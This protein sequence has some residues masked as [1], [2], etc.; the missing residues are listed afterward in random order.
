M[1]AR[2]FQ[3]VFSIAVVAVIAAIYT[4][5]HINL[6]NFKAEIAQATEQATG[7]VLQVDGDLE[8]SW[9]L[10][11]TF[12]A[13]KVSFANTEWGS[14]AEMIS[15][16]N[17]EIELAF[18]P[19][20]RQQI[21]IQKVVL[22]GPNVVVETND[23]GKGNWVFIE[24]EEQKAETNVAAVDVVI[25]EL[26][27]E[28]AMITY[29]DG[30]SGQSY[31]IQIN[32]LKVVMD[33]LDSSV[34]LLFDV[35]YDQKPLRV[36]G[37]VGSVNQLLANQI[38]PLDLTVQSGTA[39]ADIVGELATPL[40][41]KGITM[42][43][44]F[45][46]D[47]LSSLSTV[48]GIEL[49]DI[50]PIA[51]KG[52]VSD[53]EQQYN[54]KAMTLQAGKTDLQGDVSLSLAGERP[55]INADLT[56][57]LIHV[58]ELVDTMQQDSESQADEEAESKPEPESVPV[59]NNERVFSQETIKLPE[60]KILDAY[61]SLQAGKIITPELELQETE[62]ELELINGHLTLKPLNTLVE[63]SKLTTMLDFDTRE[64]IAKLNTRI[65]LTGL[66]LEDLPQLKE[67]LRGGNSDLF[68]K[69]KGQGQSIHDLMA[70]MNGNVIAKVAETDVEGS[71]LNVLSFDFLTELITKL[72]PLAKPSKGSHIVCS[73]VN[74]TI[75][76]GV[77]NS[78][79]GIAVM[80]D[81]LNI[82]G[83]GDINLQTEQIDI[84]IKPEPRKGVGISLSQLAGL[85]SVGG[86]LA[87]PAI[88]VNKVEAL[89]TGVAAGAAV[90]TGGLSVVAKGLLNRTFSDRNPCETALSAHEQ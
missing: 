14:S 12:K 19:L 4:L 90:A 60:L 81:K 64:D 5:L 40:E 70:S 29:N 8:L 75:K 77:A 16:D 84:S 73:V 51:F 41:G 53:G 25:Q 11:P 50:G 61:L 9:S 66:K 42:L 23:E 30:A 46:V 35:I 3:F 89:G 24:N 38:Y 47:T 27:I 37:E 52:Q 15:F 87:K 68:I 71:A 22:Q 36:E 86:T 18:M 74:F 2:I 76:D 56:S 57:D 69:V 82:I 31:G 85:V 72:N 26:L 39:K 80:T 65:E 1:I 62:L 55:L 54:V 43:V 20:L 79:K 33:S 59:S 49:P 83:S 44:D 45:N 21:K 58:V 34:S 17:L 10:T 28:D 32:E 63:G 67:S 13:N 78:D 6:N 7:R 88:N 48:A